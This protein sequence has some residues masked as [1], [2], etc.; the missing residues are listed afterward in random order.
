MRG[1]PQA[2]LT[3]ACRCRSGHSCRRRRNGN[4]RRLGG[5]GSRSCRTSRRRIHRCRSSGWCSWQSP[6]GWCR[7]H[8]DE[9]N[10][11][12]GDPRR[13]CRK[14]LRSLYEPAAIGGRVARKLAARRSEWLRQLPRWPP[15]SPGGTGGSRRLPSVSLAASAPPPAVLGERT[16]DMVCSTSRQR[17]AKRVLQFTR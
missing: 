7:R 12:T 2:S 5:S 13:D 9:E 6:S 17:W 1:T 8:V 11:R 4:R 15:E 14:Q 3:R 10:G 16:G